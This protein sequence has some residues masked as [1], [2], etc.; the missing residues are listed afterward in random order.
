MLSEKLVMLKWANNDLVWFNQ[1]RVDLAAAGYDVDAILKGSPPVAVNA[2]KPRQEAISQNIRVN[3]ASKL[4]SIRVPHGLYVH[5]KETAAK[6]KQTQTELL[7]SSFENAHP[8][9]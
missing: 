6:T 1:R 5:L 9:G 2:P 3:Y 8:M 7:L 4:V